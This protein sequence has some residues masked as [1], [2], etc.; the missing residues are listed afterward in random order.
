MGFPRKGRHLFNRI[1]DHFF[2]WQLFV[3]NT[4]YKAGVRT[5]FQKTPH[6]ISQKVFVA[7]NRRIDAA[8][9]IFTRLINDLLIKGFAHAVQTLEFER[10]IIARHLKDGG[11]RMRIVAGELAI[12][13]IAARQHQF[14]TS[15]IGNVG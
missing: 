3:L 7:A 13:C 9:Y 15:Q 2:D 10:A 14:R 8:R 6:Q 12:K 11:N 4:V 1:G 5:I